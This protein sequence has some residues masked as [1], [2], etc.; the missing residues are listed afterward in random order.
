MEFNSW[1]KGLIKAFLLFV[2]EEEM[3]IEIKNVINPYPPNVEN[4]V[5]S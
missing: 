1:L 4:M 3:G 5:S 2:C